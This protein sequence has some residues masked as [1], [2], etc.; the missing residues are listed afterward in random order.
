VEASPKCKANI[1]ANPSNYVG[2]V[3]EVHGKFSDSSQD[4]SYQALW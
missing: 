1:G 3:R 4:K 2:E